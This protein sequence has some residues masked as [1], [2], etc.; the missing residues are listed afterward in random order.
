MTQTI[1]WCKYIFYMH[2]CYTLL[3]PRLF[4]TD[5]D[6]ALINALKK[7]WPEAVCLLCV[8]HL[9]Q[10]ICLIDNGF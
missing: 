5:D 10:V 1:F 3:G 7:T 8:W 6:T 2:I 4:M 9:L